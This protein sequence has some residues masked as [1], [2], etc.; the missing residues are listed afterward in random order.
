M[1]AVMVICIFIADKSE[2]SCIACI[3]VIDINAVHSMTVSVKGAD[4]CHCRRADRRPTVQF[5]RRF[6]VVKC[7]ECC[8]FQSRTEMKVFPVV[9]GNGYFAGFMVIRKGYSG[10]QVNIRLKARVN[11]IICI[12]SSVYKTGKP[13]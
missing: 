4:I 12:A 5:K 3:F 6:A 10:I 9:F 8:S 7:A 2:K 13:V 11:F 1:T